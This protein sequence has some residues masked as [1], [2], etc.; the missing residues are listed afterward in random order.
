MEKSYISVIVHILVACPELKFRAN[1]SS[2][3]KRTALGLN[4]AFPSR[5]EPTLAISLEFQFQVS[6]GLERLY[7][8]KL[9]QGRC[10]MILITGAA[11]K[12][13]RAILQAL[14]PCGEIIRAFA[15]RPEQVETVKTA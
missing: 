9:I 1:S 10:S 7:I 6:G 3:L 13:G 8:S 14:N 12:T 15:H 2:A 5:L 11:G 4:R